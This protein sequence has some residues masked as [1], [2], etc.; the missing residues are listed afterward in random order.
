MKKI[1]VSQNFL[2]LFF[3]GQKGRQGIDRREGKKSL[4]IKTAIPD[5]AIKSQDGEK[6]SKQLISM[7]ILKD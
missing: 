5:N 4:S 7:L 3:L 6:A 1:L 2:V